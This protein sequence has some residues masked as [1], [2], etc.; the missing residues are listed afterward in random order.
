MDND[1]EARL[2]TIVEEIV[3][4][5]VS[6]LEQDI[7][8][9]Q[10]E[11]NEAFTRLLERTDAAAAV[12]D[13][14]GL[15]ARL[16]EDVEARVSA[17]GAATA[18]PSTDLAA[19]RDAVA[20]LGHQPSQAEVLNML[21]AKAADFAPRVVLFVVKGNSALG[22]AARGFQDGIGDSS[23]RGLSVS[24][25]SS[26]ALSAALSSHQP[27]YGSL[28]EQSE[29]EALLSRL[30]SARP[31]RVLAIPLKVR[32]KSA[33]VLYADSG[34][35]GSDVMNVEAIELLV[36]TAGFVI[37][38][39]S[40]RTRLGDASPRGEA[41]RERMGSPPPRTSGT[42]PPSATA[43]GPT[44]EAAP[45]QPVAS[46]SADSETRTTAPE[47]VEAP[48]EKPPERFTTGSL[49]GPSTDNE[50][51]QH[52]DARKFARLLVSEIKLYN[53]GK[54]L[55]GRRN[56]DLY[57]RLKEDI[58]RSRQMYDRRVTADVAAKFDYFYDELVNTL[59]EG[60]STKLGSDFPGPAVRV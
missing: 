34:S 27:V 10:R 2:T 60:D 19:L 24:L 59:A 35:A 52:N 33:A 49:R 50:E 7:S 4:S 51:K 37:E 55:E 18:A 46:P 3:R 16:A 28:D 21:V 39:T 44:P 15:L 58:D 13:N 9:V 1:F 53:E 12:H 20:E 14:N 8:R 5:R 11:V 30:G 25:Q 29:N 22:W 47:P 43:T 6:E 57:D 17:A 54:V 36:N 45:P 31:A 48:A 42:L 56:H 38:L 23:I 41:P 32:G 26:T 40:L